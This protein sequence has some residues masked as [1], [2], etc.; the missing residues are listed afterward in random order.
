[1]LAREFFSEI[2]RCYESG[3]SSVKINAQ[4]TMASIRYKDRV[5]D[6]PEQLLV[7][8]NLYSIDE[9]MYTRFINKRL[10]EMEIVDSNERESG[11]LRIERVS[12]CGN[13]IVI[14]ADFV[15][16]E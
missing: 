16:T 14:E 13:E 2:E 9:Y 6:V 7:L 8:R 5:I 11:D 12:Q 15:G 1:M 3:C 4:G 10:D